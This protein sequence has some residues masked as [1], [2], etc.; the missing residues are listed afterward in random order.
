MT[1]A[2]TQ[3]TKSPNA[4]DE[5]ISS[6]TV[7]RRGLLLAVG[8]TAMAT[9]F[10][11]YP[12]QQ[13]GIAGRVGDV[14]GLAFQAGLF[15]LWLTYWQTKAVGTGR[16]AK[17]LLGIVLVLLVLATVWSAAHLVLPNSYADTWWMLVLDACWP[18]SMIGFLVTGTVVAV[19]GR[20]QGWLRW[21]PLAAES[22]GPLAIGLTAVLPVKVAD[23]LT[24]TMMILLYGGLGTALACYPHL[25]RSSKESASPTAGQQAFP[26]E[27]QEHETPSGEAE[28][29]TTPTGQVSGQRPALPPESWRS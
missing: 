26:A 11:L 10:Y 2:P 21:A 9:T 4:D 20:W 24:P 14:G 5:V 13:G 17:V 12:V 3:S 1:T 16:R 8:A 29:M 19:V 25:T 7:A 23:F 28:P 6:G 15:G 27:G 18:L 22:W